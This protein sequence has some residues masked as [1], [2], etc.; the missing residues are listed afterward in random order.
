MSRRL[1]AGCGGALAIDPRSQGTT[2]FISGSLMD[3]SN[4][5]SDIT[6]SSLRRFWARLEDSV[7]PDDKPIFAE[8]P[9]HTFNL[10]FP[11]PAFVG[12]VDAAPIVILMSN[13]G[14]KPGITE[15]EFP[16]EASIS[17]YRRYIRG[18]VHALPPRLSPYYATG[19]VGEWIHA[20]RAVVVN[21]VPYRSPSLSS[22]KEAYNR[23]AAKHLRSLAAHRRWVMQEV[24]PEATRCRRF[25]LVHRKGWWDVPERLA[26]HCVLFSDAARAEPNRKARSS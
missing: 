21:A 17:E 19:R 10:K 3:Y 7:H 15:R 16:D 13:G 25:L 24:L 5:V 23:S 20:G 18:E 22:S 1:S 26:G 8:Y 12:D 2:A 11:P 14:Y 4:S 6:T 9:Q